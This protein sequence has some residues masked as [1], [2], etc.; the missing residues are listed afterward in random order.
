M[1]VVI[2]VMRIMAEGVGVTFMMVVAMIL[3]LN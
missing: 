1:V 2:N 3:Y